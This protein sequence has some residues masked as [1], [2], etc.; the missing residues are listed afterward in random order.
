M[1]HR[2]HEDLAILRTLLG[3]PVAYIGLLGPRVR[4]EELLADLRLG[5]FAASAEQLSRLHA[6]IG[7]DIAADNPEQIALAILSEMAAVRGGRG[8][9][10]LRDRVGPIHEPQSDNI[11]R[12]GVADADSA[13]DASSIRSS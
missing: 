8:G 4:A 11:L 12:A 13:R 1:T 9:G 2:Y 7:L 10:F 5:G 6:P 3:S